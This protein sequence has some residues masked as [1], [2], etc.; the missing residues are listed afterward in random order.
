MIGGH[1]SSLDETTYGFCAT[2][3]PNCYIRILTGQKAGIL[4]LGPLD[5]SNEAVSGCLMF[6]CA[7]MTITSYSQKIESQPH[8]ESNSYATDSNPPARG[9]SEFS[10]E[11]EMLVVAALRTPANPFIVVANEGGVRR[12]GYPRLRYRPVRETRF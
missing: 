2:P 8:G 6:C 5:N 9:P 3:G 10:L 12:R 4:S 11:E 7:L 1:W